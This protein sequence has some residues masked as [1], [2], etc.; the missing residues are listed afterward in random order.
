MNLVKNEA[1]VSW[2]EVEVSRK[3]SGF[4]QFAFAADISKTHVSRIMSGEQAVTKIEVFAKIAGA[5]GHPLE[6]VLI[7]AGWLP[8]SHDVSNEYHQRLT[9]Q[10]RIRTE[11]QLEQISRIIDT[12]EPR[13][14]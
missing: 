6:Y 11:E 4:S 12:F 7:K 5:L 13:E 3:Y 9:A 8:E 2:L 14:D 10:L 1:F